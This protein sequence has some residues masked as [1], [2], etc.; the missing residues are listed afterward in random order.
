MAAALFARGAALETRHMGAARK[1]LGDGRGMKAALVRGPRL[2]VRSK[3]R[4][5]AGDLK[6]PA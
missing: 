2:V 3:R 6:E 1:D 5:A 4:A